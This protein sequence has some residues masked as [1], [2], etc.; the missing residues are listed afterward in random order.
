[1][2]IVRSPLC[3]LKFYVIRLELF[4]RITRF[5]DILEELECRSYCCLLHDVLAGV[6]LSILLLVHKIYGIK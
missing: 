6:I 5:E 4:G 2:V 1:M 3:M